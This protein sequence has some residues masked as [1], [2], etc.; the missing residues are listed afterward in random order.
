VAVLSAGTNEGKMR[1]SAENIEQRLTAKGVKG[2]L[3]ILEG[4]D[5]TVA[6]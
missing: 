5:K 4:A 2:N 6:R 1:A 3:L